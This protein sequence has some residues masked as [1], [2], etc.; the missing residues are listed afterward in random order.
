MNNA[1]ERDITASTPVYQSL[2]ES[3]P[4]KPIDPNFNV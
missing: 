2:I 1:Y 3:V 4:H